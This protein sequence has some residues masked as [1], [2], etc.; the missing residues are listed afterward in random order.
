M[1]PS[2]R[3]TNSSGFSRPSSRQT[4]AE[5]IRPCSDPV[6]DTATN[7]ASTLTFGPTLQG[8]P[9]RAL[10]ARRKNKS[11]HEIND[12]QNIIKEN[13]IIKADKHDKKYEK[14]QMKSIELENKELREEISKWKKDHAKLMQERK[15]YFEPQVLKIDD[16]QPVSLSDNDEIIDDEFDECHEAINETFSSLSLKDIH[17]KSEKDSEQFNMTRPK[18]AFKQS[19]DYSNE[20]KRLRDKKSNTAKIKPNPKVNSASNLSNSEQIF[21]KN[22]SISRVT[23]GDTGYDSLNSSL[24]NSSINRNE[25][26]EIK[27]NL[28]NIHQP[29]IISTSMSILKSSPNSSSLQNSNIKPSLKQLKTNIAPL[30]GLKLPK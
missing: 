27:K 20:H 3:L 17:H 19:F 8:N 21:E 2:S 11:Q 13:L 5:Q 18:S 24:S 16:E 12:N 26:D 25:S 4:I 23:T 9:L 15:K 7:D 1:R 14:E 22:E 30:S 10:M 6:G 29:K 28:I